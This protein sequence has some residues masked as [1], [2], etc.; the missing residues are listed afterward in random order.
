MN[1]RDT[2]LLAILVTLV[3]LWTEV[4]KLYMVVQETNRLSCVSARVSL[5]AG[6]LIINITRDQE[7]RIEFEKKGEYT[8]C[9]DK[10]SVL[11]R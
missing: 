8:D 10:E 3:L 4:D 5:V 7:E 11:L 1:I 2:L 9:P 6:E